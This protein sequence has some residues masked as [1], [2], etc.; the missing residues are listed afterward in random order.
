MGSATPDQAELLE[1]LGGPDALN[2]FRTLAHNPK[3]MKSWLR[4]GGRLL[5]RSSLP[6]RD[7]ELVILRVAALC[8]CDYEWGQHV[9]IARDAGLSD[10]EIVR[11]AETGSDAGPD[12]ASDQGWTGHEAALLRAVD[13]LIGDHRIDES[14][15]AELA[16]T[17]AESQLIEFTLLAG[18]YSMLAGTLS[19][20]GVETETPLPRIGHV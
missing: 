2:L 19:S 17:Y 1:A 13:Q 20:I 12:G 10:D 9:G 18:H 6:A 11:V 16:R 3:V 15:W 5:Q 14:T 8:R 4:F 7:R